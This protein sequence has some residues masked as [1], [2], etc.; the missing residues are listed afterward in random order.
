[1]AVLSTFL[2]NQRTN[3]AA[4]PASLKALPEN[5]DMDDLPHSG[6]H[7]RFELRLAGGFTLRQLHGGGTTEYEADVELEVY[8]DADVDVEAIHNTIADDLT[9]ASL[10]MLKVG[11][12]NAGIHMVLPNG[13]VTEQIEDT[14]YFRSL[15]TYTVI[16]RETQDTT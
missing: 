1:M 4:S 2:T 8:H 16:F 3:L 14:T 12:W 13:F 5:W 11:N 9:D 6:I 15:G 7:Q 10:V